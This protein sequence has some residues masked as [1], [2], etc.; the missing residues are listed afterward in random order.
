MPARNAV[1]P[2]PKKNLYWVDLIFL[3]VAVGGTLFSIASLIQSGVLRTSLTTDPQLSWHLS[4]AAGLTA[5]TLMAASTIWGLFLS[6]HLLK[7]WTPGPVSLLLHAAV[8]WLAVGISVVHMGAL[9]FD[10]YYKYTLA[11]LL[12]P[13]I[14]PYRPLAVGLG[15]LAIWLTLAI[16]LSF[17]FRRLIGQKVWR[18]LHYTSYAAFALI[19]LHSV[20]A[21]TDMT[22]PGMGILV[23]AS[24]VAV[25]GLL[26]WRVLQALS[27]P[28]PA[29]KRRAN[30]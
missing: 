20:M 8:S 26:S 1:T 16:T 6:S 14:G 19:T 25:S 17:S 30:P 5:Y 23:G 13:F 12:V 21:G 10:G 29:A 2:A 22:K 4:R 27:A 15:V 11:D 3:L 9:L 28:K 18:W 7:N 24:V